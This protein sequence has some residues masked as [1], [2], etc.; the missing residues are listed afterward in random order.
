[1]T[2][3][4][5]TLTEAPNKLSEWLLSHEA[6]RKTVMKWSRFLRWNKRGNI[7]AIVFIYSTLKIDCSNFWMVDTLD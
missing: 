1:M 6:Q 5:D 3:E 4:L 2:E 7:Y